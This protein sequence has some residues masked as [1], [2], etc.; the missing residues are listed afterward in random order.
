M[1]SNTFYYSN[2]DRHTV[3][4]LS[5]HVLRG[6]SAVVLGPRGV[7]KRDLL[8]AVNHAREQKGM[9]RIAVAAFVAG[10]LIHDE[11]EVTRS[12]AKSSQLQPA[13]LTI[14]SWT[15]RVRA[16]TS[17]GRPLRLF[18]T[19][20]EGVAKRLAHQL[21]TA[22]QS[23][24]KQGR[25]VTLVTGEGNLIDLVD[26]G[27]NSAW[28]CANLYV[29]HAHGF[30]EFCH[31]VLKR[32][33]AMGMGV[34]G[35]LSHA[36]EALRILYDRTG[37]NV[38]LARAVLWSLSERWLMQRQGEE[39]PAF[40]LVDTIKGS[41]IPGTLA[42]VQSMPTAGLHPFHC[43]IECLLAAAREPYV[44][45][46]PLSYEK[47]RA[48]V[49]PL[50]DDLQLLLE[51]QP[52][53]HLGEAP[54]VT[55][56]AGLTR[57]VN[58]RLHWAGDYARAC[59]V[60]YFTKQRLG[61]LYALAHSWADAYRL[62]ADVAQ[63]QKFRPTSDDDDV[64]FM[65]LT[66]ALAVHFQRVINDA[67][68]R[69][70]QKANGENPLGELQSELRRAI[71][72]LLG[73]S[74]ENITWW[75]LDWQGTWVCSTEGNELPKVV[76]EEWAR[77]CAHA[78]LRETELSGHLDGYH[79]TMSRDA[80]QRPMAA[81]LLD[82]TKDPLRDHPVRMGAIHRVFRGYR[83]ARERWAE[84][85]GLQERIAHA[86]VESAIFAKFWELPGASTWDPEETLPAIA[87]GICTGLPEL[88]RA[89]FCE[90]VNTDANSVGVRPVFDTATPKRFPMSTIS[91]PKPERWP[92]LPEQPIP[93]SREQAVRACELAGLA[94]FEQ[95]GVIISAP[96]I[97]GFLILESSAGRS[98]T[99]KTLSFLQS[100]YEKLKPIWD[101][102]TRLKLL[103]ESIN[104]FSNP[105]V[106]LDRSKR[107]MYA[108]QEAID[109]LKLPLKRAGW[110][111]CPWSVGEG[112][113]P[114]VQKALEP[115]KVAGH[116]EFLS[117]TDRM[118]GVWL[119]DSHPMLNAEGMPRG[120]VLTF[121]NRAFL[122]ESFNLLG[123]LQKISDTKDALDLI[124]Y[125]VLKLLDA[126]KA[127]VRTY[128]ID[129]KDKD[130]LVSHKSE[131]LNPEHTKLFESGGIRFR[132]NPT[133]NAWRCLLR[134]K[135]RAYKLDDSKR[136]GSRGQTAKGLL[137]TY[138]RRTDYS[139]LLEKHTGSVAIDFPSISGK[140]VIGKLTV[141]FSS[142]EAEALAPD[143]MMQMG[144]LS[145]VLADL[146]DRVNRERI[147]KQQVLVEATEHA[148][149]ETA[150]N[151]LSQIS[152]FANII[153]SYRRRERD[154]PAL[155]SINDRLEEFYMHARNSVRRIKDRV[156]QVKIQPVEADLV[157]CL[158]RA[159]KTVLDEVHPWTISGLPRVNGSWDIIH[160]ENA[161]IELANNSRDFA[162]PD[163]PL[164]VQV[165]VSVRVG[166]SATPSKVVD[167][168]YGDNGRGVPMQ[169]K[170]LIFEGRSYRD[171][172]GVPSQGMGL[173]Y[174]KKVA[175][176]HGGS[177]RE[178][179]I[180]GEGA[181]FNIELPFK[182]LDLLA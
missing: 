34:D 162:R 105:T 46:R 18:L 64:V 1:T 66:D 157:Q 104:A 70:N 159:L 91:F 92:P 12:L 102:A 4:R 140:E 59:A 151:L 165:H 109:R 137:Y 27:P 11:A 121:R 98:L 115:G 84:A 181:I 119:R 53:P 148:L 155:K 20:L 44:R 24:C 10:K 23:L 107:I 130:L 38:S 171:E 86:A 30:R 164:E 39:R 118:N 73:F 25:L 167:I 6:D 56:L 29:V 138:I 144:A 85:H 16:E 136:P 178:T 153:V 127:K 43:A 168:T 180:H 106:I 55:E 49:V 68:C 170:P 90:T 54:H 61:D 33:R 19:N 110:Q 135:P 89:I 116:Q 17:D 47:H 108:N 126:Q 87:Q 79:W 5:E 51:N 88:R 142:E 63:S 133:H 152:G 134:R 81:V 35:P 67:I 100:L 124:Y 123:Q 146:L 21:L 163:V 161:F 48:S 174:L 113:L 75:H 122:Y 145:F 9:E 125:K 69:N 129:A 150:H 60:G 8:Q 141:E 41:D 76:R 40:R 139:D 101:Q 57:R 147:R 166:G 176:A 7:G 58:G 50:L 95:G 177:V 31:F 26:G 160:W 42:T 72:D 156:G 182:S 13:A 94:R 99:R 114:P 78:S 28:S 112:S 77:L 52:G 173:S 93:F 37:G 80:D 62:Y 2:I 71:V 149:A 175:E 179:G 65:R 131:G 32:I 82:G 3:D 22:I 111:F 172:V 154:L 45:G 36:R 120:Y 74:L 15:D 143:I 128:V 169:L 158:E 103:H 83:R 132:R 117:I 96:K 97:E 14:E